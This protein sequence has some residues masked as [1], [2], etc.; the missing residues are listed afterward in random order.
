MGVKPVLS[1]LPSNAGLAAQI[2]VKAVQ[3]QDRDDLWRW[4]NDPYTRAHSLN[5]DIVPFEQHCKWFESASNSSNQLLLLGLIHNSL[6]PESIE[7]IGMVR[8]DIGSVN[9]LISNSQ[10]AATNNKAIVSINLNPDFRGRGLSAP[11]LLAA[12]A[13]FKNSITLRASPISSTRYIEATI[14]DDNKASIACFKRAGFVVDNTHPPKNASSER[15]GQKQ[16][17]LLLD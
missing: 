3:P 9:E 4:R 1:S 2:I 6:T 8:F 17:R 7:K 12:I 14:K 15:A 10:T 13:S 5:T 16:F 11:L